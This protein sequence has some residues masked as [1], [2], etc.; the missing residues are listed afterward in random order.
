MTHARYIDREPVGE[1]AKDAACRGMDPALFHSGIGKVT[2]DAK[3]VCA[4][5][6]VKQACGDHALLQDEYDG[7]WGGLT[8]D[9]RKQLRRLRRAS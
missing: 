1:W 7:L 3:K 6:P 2:L 4:R 5:C 9:E 8:A